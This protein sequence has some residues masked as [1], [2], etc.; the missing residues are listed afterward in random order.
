MARKR[1][2][3]GF[4]GTT[5]DTGKQGNRWERW[6]P[7]VA[8]CQHEDFLVD[9][10]ELLHDRRAGSLAEQVRADI[11]GVSPET[12]VRSQPM[13][14]RDPWDFEEVYGALWGFAAGKF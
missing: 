4:L 5:L 12:E 8:L 11:G 1:V 10:L 7:T 2:V 6:R 13:E 14:L 3:I 9:R